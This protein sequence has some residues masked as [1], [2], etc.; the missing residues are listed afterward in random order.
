LLRAAPGRPVTLYDLIIF[1]CDGVLVDSEPIVNRVFVDM[2][3]ELGHSLDY[4]ATLRHFSGGNMAKR[5]AYM[6]HDL[7]SGSHRTASSTHS[8]GVLRAVL[9]RDL[10]SGAGNH[11]GVGG[12]P[13]AM[14]R[15]VERHARGHAHAARDRGLLAQFDPPLF[16]ATEVTR[17]KPAPDLFLH[18]AAAMGTA[19][20]RCVV[21]E[22]SVPGVE[23]GVAAGMTVLG[24]A[25]IT[26]AD[27]LGEAGADVFDD[28]SAS[29]AIS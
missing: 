10:R 27:A 25:R 8:I 24:F 18:A 12:R 28:M 11:G 15:G 19:A 9:E 22:D 16:S 20:G 13:Y 23:A 29:A 6:E 4:E 2:V 7:G 21:V 14:V 1:D 17:P 3:A 26:E 5:L